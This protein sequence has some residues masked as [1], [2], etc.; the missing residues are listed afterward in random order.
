MIKNVQNI[1]HEDTKELS[2]HLAQYPVTTVLMLL[3]S[4]ISSVFPV[5]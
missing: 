4:L 3:L 5:D 2:I 1:S